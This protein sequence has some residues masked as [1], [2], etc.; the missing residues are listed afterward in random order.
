MACVPKNP[1]MDRNYFLHELEIIKI[2]KQIFN[3]KCKKIIFDQTVSTKKNCNE[4]YQK[5]F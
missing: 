4:T 5:M 3:V 2:L 1:L